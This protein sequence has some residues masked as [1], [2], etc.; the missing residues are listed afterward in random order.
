AVEVT[1]E[2]AFDAAARLASGLAGRE[3]SL[4]V[5]GGLDVVADAGERDHVQCPVQLSVAAAVEPVP[6]LFPGRG[7]HRAGAG[8]GGEGR[9]ARHPLRVA[10][11]DEQL[12]GADGSDAGLAEQSRG[13]LGNR[14]GEGAPELA[15][16]LGAALDSTA[17]SA[18]DSG[19]DLR[20]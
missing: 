14:R 19:G 5:G 11:G 1:C 12:R 8:E 17:K 10:A 18:E 9:L 20:A 15:D 6:L 16:L 4:V 3:E 7:L 13:K 2:R